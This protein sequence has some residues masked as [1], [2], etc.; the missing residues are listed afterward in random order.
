MTDFPCKKKEVK[1]GDKKVILY[2]LSLGFMIDFEAGNT[3]D[4]FINII[5]DASSLS[6]EEAKKIRR[7]EAEFLTKEI[8]L[9]TYGEQKEEENAEGDTKKS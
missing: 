5:V 3:D 7:S 1:L 2:D 4:S 9:L 8:M 6:E